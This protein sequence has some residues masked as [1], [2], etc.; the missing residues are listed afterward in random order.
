MIKQF[1]AYYYVWYLFLTKKSTLTIFYFSLNLNITSSFLKAVFIHT[2]LK[3]LS[4]TFRNQC[5]LV[6]DY[7]IIYCSNSLNHSIC[8]IASLNVITTYNKFSI[9]VH[10]KICTMA[11]KNKL[12]FTFCFPNLFN[13][14]FNHFTINVILWL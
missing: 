6:S 4:S 11:S 8:L 14:L 12:S 9:S 5:N 3:C 1:F 10:N 7:F 13:N 2:K